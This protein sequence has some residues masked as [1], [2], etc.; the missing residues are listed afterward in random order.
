MQN[1]AFKGVSGHKTAYASKLCEI[2]KDAACFA[3]S[4]TETIDSPEAV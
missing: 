2:M 3:A 4:M 1:L